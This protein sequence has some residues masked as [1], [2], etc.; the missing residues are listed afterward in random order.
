MLAQA[1]RHGSDRLPP[2]LSEDR[3]AAVRVRKAL[4]GFAVHQRKVFL[5]GANWSVQGET[6]L[7]F[8][9]CAGMQHLQRRVLDACRLSG[10]VFR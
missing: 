9:C 7:A 5:R 3:V 1:A 6:R 8:A 10:R 4:S 2:I